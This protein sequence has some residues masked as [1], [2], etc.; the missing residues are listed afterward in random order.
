MINWLKNLFKK[1]TKIQKSKLSLPDLFNEVV[2]YSDPSK[3]LSVSVNIN[4]YGSRIPKVNWSITDINI[5]YT[6]GST[7]T[8]EQALALYKHEIERNKIKNASGV[9]DKPE[10]LED[11][12]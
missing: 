5:N 11:V 10:D 2:K 4:N 7:D 3:P 8:A 9:G 1:K 6:T 12:I